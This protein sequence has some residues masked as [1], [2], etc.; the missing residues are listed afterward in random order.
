MS[1]IFDP[2]GIIAPVTIRLKALLQ[3]IWRLGLK[4]DNQIPSDPQHK[5]QKILDS[6]L[7]MERLT[8]PRI[9]FPNQSNKSWS[10]GIQAFTNASLIGIA[11][12]LFL[13]M[14]NLDKTVIECKFLIGKSKVAPI[15]Q[16][17]VPKLELEAATIGARLLSFASKELHLSRTAVLHVWTDSQVVLD[18]IKSTK[19]Q[20]TF[21]ANRLTEISTMDHQLQWHHIPTTLNPADHGT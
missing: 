7:R 1:S 15:K 2:L 16:L 6:F 13:R 10:L 5:L 17:S 3:Q 12:V 20:K 9:F 21:V 18:G 19:Q 8:L 14:H 11:A 4:W